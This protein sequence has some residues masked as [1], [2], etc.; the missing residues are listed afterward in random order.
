MNSSETEKSHGGDEP[1]T[2]V[3]EGA[4]D[5]QVDPTVPDAVESEEPEAGEDAAA[6]PEEED[7]MAAL[8]RD[9]LKYKELAMRTA[10]DMENFRKRAA[11]DRE[12]SVRYANQGLLE[13]LLPILDNFEMGM[14]AAG[15]EQGSMIYIGMDMVR[16]QLNDF[17]SNQGVEEIEAA[18]QEFD[19]NRHDAVAQ[20]EGGEEGRVLRVTRR[21]FMLRDRLLRP[22]SVVV[23]TGPATGEEAQSEGEG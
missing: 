5:E 11:R 21:G 10:A 18:G 23:A 14:Q 17:L 9:V 4:A 20:E 6:A 2:A 22:A 13:D 3:P 16:K 1:E 8:E 19:P 15:Q 12:E 7:P